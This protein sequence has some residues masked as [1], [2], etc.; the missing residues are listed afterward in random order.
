MAQIPST[1]LLYVFQLVLAVMSEHITD[2]EMER[3]KEFV[4][5][6]VYERDPEQLV[7]ESEDTARAE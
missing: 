7:P 4:R 5:T 6:P 2:S 3:I 1:S